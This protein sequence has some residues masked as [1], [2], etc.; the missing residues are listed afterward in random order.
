MKFLN[1]SFALIYVVTATTL[2]WYYESTISME[3]GYLD[4]DTEYFIL[5]P[6]IYYLTILS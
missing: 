2:D 3:F 4:T 5:T 6:V 1:K